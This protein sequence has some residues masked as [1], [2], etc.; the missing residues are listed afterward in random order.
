MSIIELIE[1]K[2]DGG[3]L[4][5]EEIGWIIAQYSDDAI[6]DYQ[7]SSLLMAVFKEGLNHDELSAWTDAM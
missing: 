3:V 7:M 5:A 1:R 6:P 2:R 4:T